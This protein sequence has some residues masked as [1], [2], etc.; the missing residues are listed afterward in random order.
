MATNLLNLLRLNRFFPLFLT[1]FFGAFNDNLYK[2]AL[3]ILITYSFALAL[4]EHTELLITVASGLFILPFFIFSAP[5]GQ[6]ADKYEKSK[7]ISIIKF[8]EIILALIAGVGFYTHSIFILMSV[9]FLLGTQAAFFGPVKYSILPEQLKTNELIAG[10]AL[11][12]AGTFF[13]ILLGTIVGG[14]LASLKIGASLVAILSFLIAIAGFITSL[15]IPKTTPADPNI[16]LNL[17]LWKESLK[18]VRYTSSQKDLSFAI[19]G[20]SW[21]WLI[22]ATY[23]SQFPT[24]ARDVLS[25]EPSIVTLFL[26]VFTAGIGLGSLLCNRLLKDKIDATYVPLAALGMS[27]FA[28]DLVLASHQV[29]PTHGSLISLFTFV[30]RLADLRIVFDLFLLAICGGIYIVPLYAILQHESDPLH[31]SRAIASNNIMNAMFMVGAAVVTSA[32]LIL[33]FSITQVFFVAAAA[34]LLVAVYICNLLPEALIKSFL[35]WIF[36]TLYR[37]EVHGMENYY[38]A[39]ERVLIVANHTSFLDAAMLSAL[40]PDR[41]T[42][43]IDTNIAKRWWVKA[44]LKLVNTYSVD[45]TNP[46]A[47]KSI[48]EYLRSNKRV[49][50]FPE[51]R[52]TVT[53]S[54]MKIF[55]GPGLIA[56]KA[57]APMLPI[58]IDGAQYTPFSYLRGKLRIRWFP[59]ITLTI[60]EPRHFEL[61]AVISGRERRQ[62]IS[63]QLYDIM[64]DAMF[65]SSD[66][67]ITIFQS[68]LDAKAVHGKKQ[69]VLED[70]E[71]NPMNYKRLTLASIVL[72]RQIAKATQPGEYV[73]LLLPN[74]VGCVATFFALQA[75]HRVPAML[76]FSA[77]VHNVVTACKTAEI[78]LVY[79]SRRFIDMAELQATENALIQN[80]VK[81]VYLEDVRQQIGLFSKLAGMLFNLM[82]QTYYR[83]YNKIN[84]QN[85]SSFADNPAVVLFTS[86]SEG[87]PK[88]V[89]LSHKNIQANRFQVTARVDFGPKD[90]VFNALP[91]FHSFGLTAATLLPIIS[92]MRVFMYPSPLHY[93]IIPELC[94]DI[95]ATVFFGTDTFLSNYAKYAHPYNFYSVRYVFAGAE[96]LRDETRRLWMEKFGIRIME[97]YGVTE[98][99]PVIAANTPMQY[100]LGSV[101]RILPG[102]HYYLE[103]VEGIKEGARLHVSGPN[104]MMGYLFANQPGVI[105]PPPEGR[106]D[107]GD[108]VAID[109]DGY[110]SIKGRAKRFAKIAGEMVSLTMVEEEIYRLWP[111]NQ[112]AVLSQPDARKGEQIILLTNQPN[113][114]LGQLVEAFKLR[115]IAEISLP[116]KIFFIEE[117]PVLGSGKIDFITAKK[118][119]EE[120]LKATGEDDEDMLEAAG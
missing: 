111:E 101:G 4:P 46:L 119:M 17:N 37:A 103:P 107:T 108:I 50:I 27:V 2:N 97:G 66:T 73:G 88:G 99:S 113:A 36:K 68:L 92:G 86:G 8:S 118:V 75:H 104:I 43:A 74:S 117:L 61:P 89:V 31:R 39:G 96:R 12:E 19:F 11:I 76:N 77:G 78:K 13:A 84:K 90:K 116:R 63:A 94:Y 15:S 85:E 9:L 80:G 45:P 109:N 72:G 79:T 18:I 105:V 47:T 42:F 21:F 53:G 7:L 55:E 14:I 44:F 16:K 69:V 114:T 106:H 49:V 20:I 67:Q 23:L 87:T 56:D 28:F 30:T 100:K 32:M 65:F 38:K 25:A 59:K 29:H 120:A 62:Q 24:Y 52:I 71:R 35:I 95:G 10:N 3:V 41:L 51:G 91:M 98:A 58:R 110:I 26:T 93:R 60:L 57:D 1:Q 33:H 54:L 70:I 64:T 22:G 112:H 102:M 83:F 115:G 6:L 40:L 81:L 48:I 5:A 82:P 34:N